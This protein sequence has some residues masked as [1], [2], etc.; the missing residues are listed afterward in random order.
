[1]GSIQQ[2][3][4]RSIPKLT[5]I[6]QISPRGYARYIFPFELGEN[7]NPD[8]IFTVVRQGYVFLAKQIPETA[9]EVIPDLDSWQKNVMK[10]RMP[11]DGEIDLVTAKDL[12]A[13]GAFPYTFAELKAKSFPP[14]AFEGDLLCRREVW[15]TPDTRRPIS[16][17]QCTFIPGGLLLSWNV[18]HMIGDGG[19]FFTWAKVWAEGCRRAQGQDIDNPVQLPE[20]LWKDREQAINPPAQYKGK[21][22][23][24]PEYI[25]LPFTPTEMPPKMLTTTHRGQ[26]FYISPES[27]AKLKQEADPSNA[28]ESSDQ[29]WISTNDAICALIWRSIMAAQFP[30]QPEGLGEAEESDSETNFGIFMDGRLRT[31]PKIHP[32]ALGCFMTCCTA[33]VSLRKMLGRL[34]IADLSVLVRKAVASTEG[35]S[36]CDVAALVKNQEHPTR[37][38]EQ[39]TFTTGFLPFDVTVGDFN[40][41]GRPDIVATNLGDNTVNVFLGTGSGS[42]QPQTTFPTG[43]LPAGVAVGEFNGDGDLDIVT[44]NNVGVNILLGTGSGTF[45]APATFAADSGPQDVTVGDFNEDGFLDIVTAN[46]GINSVSVFLGTGSGS[47]QAP[48]TLL[49]GASPVAVAV[50]DFNGDGYLDIVTANAG[51]NT[52]NI[53]LGTGSGN[54]QNPTSFQVGSLPQGVA[55]GDFNGDGDLDIVATNFNDNTVSVLLGTGSGSFQPQATFTVGNGPSGVAVGDFN[56][57]GY[58]DIVAANSNEK[59]VSVLLGTG[60][61]SFQPQATFTVGTSPSGVALGDFNGDGNLDIVTANQSDGTVSVLLSQP[62]DA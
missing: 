34:N 6:E 61:G 24:H 28:T 44:T 33:T 18:F 48:A 54:F 52:V 45:Q 29:K 7:Y 41:D 39:E 16:L 30:L 11:S 31:N 19:C 5:A 46:S 36:I 26:I 2:T 20:A 17:A 60:S 35:H 57:D 3:T 25:L 14:S 9:C 38:Q 50:G 49:A 15:P 40:G 1:M 56:G 32:E 27:L 51:D 10:L 58:L 37:F 62:C 4:S 55:V 12:R 22:E 53:L 13:P 47:F 43:T 23:D 21:L 8:E 59:S 42:F